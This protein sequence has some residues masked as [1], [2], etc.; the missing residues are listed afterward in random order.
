MYQALYRKWRPRK[1]KDVIGQEHITETLKNEISS[2]RVSHAYLFVGSRGTG[3]TTCAKIFSRAVNCLSPA[4]G[5]P[6]D[7]CEICKEIQ[8]ESSLDII[9]IDAASNNS[10]D[11]IRSMRDE[12]MFTPAKCK[13]RV[14]IVDEV[15]MLSPGAF[16]AFL[17]ILEEPPKHVIFILAT[18]EIHKIPSTIISRCQRFNFS[19]ISEKH[20]SERINF[21]CRQEEIKIESGATELIAKSADGGMRDAISILDQCANSCSGD[22]TLGKAE[23]ILGITNSEYVQEFAKNILNGSCLESISLLDQLHKESK[24]MRKLCEEILEKFRAMMM[25]SLNNSEDSVPLNKIL[26]ILDI[27]QSTYQNIS[28]GSN[29]KLE[30]EI[31]FAKLCIAIDEKKEAAFGVNA[32]TSNI[33]KHKSSEEKTIKPSQSPPQESELKID[34]QPTIKSEI[35]LE[36]SAKSTG[37]ISGTPFK[38]WNKILDKIQEAGTFKSLCIS[39]KESHAYESG[40]FVLIDSKNPLAFELLRDSNYRI[41]IKKIIKDITGKQYNLGP[42]KPVEKA[43]ESRDPLDS[44]IETAQKNNIDVTVN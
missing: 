9:E 40:N 7:V 25:E 36:T 31:A 37:D 30:M 2:G 10:V 16:N 44:L 18:T 38:D 5:D 33:Q 29:P 34:P 15:H 27:L 42:Y 11:N 14:Y 20:I 26:K 1:F 3:K 13:Y 41:A 39:L 35:P 8:D 4:N 32:Q 23:Q 17:K 43:K 22:I 6:C 24:N 12:V 19:R 21:I 28:S